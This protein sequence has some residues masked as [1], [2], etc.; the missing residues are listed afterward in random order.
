MYFASSLVAPIIMKI[1]KKKK[2]QNMK[3]IQGL[4]VKGVSVR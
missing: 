1:S 4:E 3:K 2:R